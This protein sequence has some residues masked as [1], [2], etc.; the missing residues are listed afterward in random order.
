MLRIILLTVSTTLALATARQDT[1]PAVQSAR[2]PVD[3][4]EIACD[5]AGAGTPV[6]FLHGAFMDRT[7]W[8][9]QFDVFA[10]RHRVVRYDI[11]PFGESSR[12]DVAYSVPGDLVH[13]LDHLSIAR[14]H[15]VGHSFGG[16]TA[17]DFAVLHPDRVSSLVLAAAPPSGFAGPADERKAAADVFAA[18]KSGDDAI[19]Q[20]WLAHPMWTVSRSMPAVRRELEA[21]TRRNL[22]PFRMTFA[23]YVPL[24]PPAIE[25][26]RDVKSVTLLLVGDADTPGNRQAV[27]V[28]AAQLPA[29]SLHVV[30]GADHGLPLGWAD[31][32]NATVLE[33]ISRADSGRR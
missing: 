25:R 24:K 16:S 29:A 1:S 31:E 14:A 19:V 28:L 2:L 11:R 6:V 23:P 27:D 33:F 32:F 8:N 3:G 18:V 7:S 26:L 13:L 21:I 20:A 9:R 5:V 17:L 4:G 10:R 22:A 30:K 15:L 12:P